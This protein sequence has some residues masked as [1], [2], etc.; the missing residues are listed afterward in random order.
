MS[1][2]TLLNSKFNLSVSLNDKAISDGLIVLAKNILNAI[3]I[4]IVIIKAVATTAVI[5][6]LSEIDNNAQW[7][8]KYLNYLYQTL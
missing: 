7:N 2:T 1:N 3:A 5:S 4:I 6:L 8:S